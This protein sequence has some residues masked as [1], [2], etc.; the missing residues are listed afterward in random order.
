MLICS[1]REDLWY[2]HNTLITSMFRVNIWPKSV[3]FVSR[4]HKFRLPFL[5]LL[6]P[7]TIFAS[8]IKRDS[9]GGGRRDQ[10]CWER[11]EVQELLKDG[12]QH[13]PGLQYPMFDIRWTPIWRVR[14]AFCVF[15]LLITT[16]YKAIGQRIC[17]L[18]ALYNKELNIPPIQR[19]FPLGC[20]LE[21]PRRRERD[22][23]RGGT[24]RC[25][26]TLALAGCS[27]VYGY[28]VGRN[29]V[30][31][32]HLAVTCGFLPNDMRGSWGSWVERRTWV[33]CGSCC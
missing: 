13:I 30:A 19:S 18:P 6:G 20:R 9:W 3:L 25:L 16:Y 5:R 32:R 17:G 10:T 11:K 28:S 27:G 29:L 26:D 22:F 1:L 23:G 21:A 7:T 33:A 15:V 24:Q 14:D 4:P 12:H 8:V 2:R 31:R